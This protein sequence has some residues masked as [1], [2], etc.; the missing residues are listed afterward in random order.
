MPS[1]RRRS[2]LALLA[3]AAAA[4][5]V[6]IIAVS[7]PAG[8]KAP[9]LRADPVE[10]IEGPAVYGAGDVGSLGA[11]RLLVRFNGFVTNV[12]NGPL[13]VSGNPQVAGGVD[14]YAWSAGQSG[15]APT[16]EVTDPDLRVIYETADGHNHFHLMRA[17]EYSLWNLDRTAQ[18][19]P[20]Q[21][22]GF[23]LYDSMQAPSSPVPPASQVYVAEVTHFCESGNSGSTSLRMGV[24]PGWRDL[25]GKWLAYQWV[26]VSRT[27]PGTYL[28]A[29]AADP[30][31][32]IWEGD[33]ET[34]PRTFASRQVTVP[35][36][37]A[38]PITLT[39]ANAAQAVSLQATRVGS[40]G[41]QRFTIV[42]PPAHGSLNQAPGTAFAGPTVT[43][44]PQAG[45]SGPDA[46]IYVARD[47]NS[48]FPIS[49]SEP[50]ATVSLL[51]AAPAVAISGAP[52]SLIAGTSAQLSAVVS[53]ASGG[54]T[55]STTAGTISPT[56]LLVAPV[57]PPPGGTLTVR[58][59][60]TASPSLNA[61]AVIAV[62]AAP[63]AQPAPLPTA[64]SPPAVTAAASTKLLSRLTA[65][66]AGRRIVVGTVTTGP[67]AGRVDVIVSFA[68]KVLGRCGARVGPRKTV[69]C[70]I[71]LT[72]DY[73]LARVRF[74]ARLS[75]LGK[76]SAVRRAFV[77]VRPANHG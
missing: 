25:Y 53:G 56:G 46:F 9:D 50:N 26:D 18:V 40:P 3:C 72:R 77:Q 34:N 68:G 38:K 6:P 2:I 37:I 76:S 63:V 22:V 57:T 44:T 28:V 29:S 13:E 75:I 23:C 39:Q 33:G 20:G 65:G 60:S 30:G 70:K 5:A 51:A 43:Y 71:I 64:V 67:K 54:V 36:Y 32:S 74:T 62:S 4:V 24:S 12:G 16:V 66:H 35:G 48:G 19:A 27:S 11:N 42:T 47:A 73:P 55:W 49:G 10:A 14:Q 7:A 21:K 15:G 58:A 52:A 69:S 8:T 31:D 59:T 41:P 17:M 61:Q 45:Y 1:P